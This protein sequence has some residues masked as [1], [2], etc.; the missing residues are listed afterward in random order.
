MPLLSLLINFK[1]GKMFYSG[2]YGLES[3]QAKFYDHKRFFYLLRLTAYFSFIFCYGFIFIADV[4]ILGQVDSGYQLYILAI[5]TIVLQLLL[6][7][8]TVL[9]FRKGADGL[10]KD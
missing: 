8:L 1:C 6:I 7:I 9:E 3:T 4:I 5:E 10:L 2:F